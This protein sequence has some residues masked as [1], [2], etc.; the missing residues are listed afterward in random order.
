M[1]VHWLMTEYF[2]YMTRT[3]RLGGAGI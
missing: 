2:I 3:F 1:T